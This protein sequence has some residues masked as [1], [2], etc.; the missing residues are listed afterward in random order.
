MPGGNATWRLCAGAV[1]ALLLLPG[2]AG[3]TTFCVPDFGPGCAAGGGRVAIA[4]LEEALAEDGFD[5]QPDTVVVQPGTYTDPDTFELAGTDDLVLR[6]AGAG[7]T[8]LT[9]SD[10]GNQFVLNFASG[11]RQALV[12]DL[13]VVVPASFPD[14][15]GGA[16]IQADNTVLRDVDVVS[17][18]PGA[19]GIPSW[20]SGGRMVG[21]T[22]RTAGAGTITDAINTA[23]SQ[24][25]ADVEIRGV[26]I[27]DAGYGVAVTD[28]DADV[29]VS[30]VTMRGIRLA[31]AYVGP[32]NLEIANSVIRTVD[33][34]SGL[35]AQRFGAGD[36]TMDADQ[37]TAVHT[38]GDGQGAALASIVAPGAAGSTAIAATSSI[39]RGYD[40]GAVRTAPVGAD[41][42]ANL[43]VS[44]SNIDTTGATSAGD[45]IFT[46]FNNID[47]NPRFRSDSILALRRGSPSLDA[48]DPNSPFD[49]DLLGN[50]RPTEGDGDPP[51]LVDQGAFELDLVRPRTKIMAGPGK[52]VRRGIARFEFRSNEP[53]SSFRCK[54]DQRRFRSCRTGARLRVRAGEHVF[55]VQA[56]DYG[57]NRDRTPARKRFTVPG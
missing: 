20:A 42:N 11:S 2:Q 39:F 55:R 23:V 27:R 10:D 19:D 37:V 30:G 3:A 36:G 13:S 54:L 41:G 47:A 49:D 14:G 32:G 18:N 35:M 22:I 33:G 38:P 57:G 24:T 12:R 51:A 44:Y 56:I 7:R 43:F 53:L 52:R 45:G 1:V 50:P 8:R 5:G 48:G 15:V 26:T 46:T 9:S 31:G 21:G 17:R 25:G 6:G 28:P 40:L 4:D 16:A 34:G 29:T